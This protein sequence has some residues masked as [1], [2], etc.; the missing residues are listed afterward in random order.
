MTKEAPAQQ[1]EAAT[2][3]ETQK[4]PPQARQAVVAHDN[5][6]E[7]NSPEDAYYCSADFL[8]QLDKLES[9][10]REKLQHRKKVICSPPSFSLGISLE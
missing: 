1:G 3:K 8:D 6:Q 2:D 7:C 9:I 10:A 4:T 5:I